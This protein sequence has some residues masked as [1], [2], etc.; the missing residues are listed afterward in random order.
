MHLA[1]HPRPLL[2]RSSRVG[3]LTAPVCLPPGIEHASRWPCAE[4]ELGERWT[5]LLYTDGLVEGR[6][7]DGPMR[8]GSEGL[9][10][11]MEAILGGG[12]GPRPPVSAEDL[13]DSMVSRV[14]ELNGGD[15]DDD[16]AVLALQYDGPD[17]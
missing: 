8:L 1:G 11:I 6:T 4:I 15:L 3:E 17:G 12:E 7:G 5:V 14:R 9:I 10:G 2:I 13:L 16:L